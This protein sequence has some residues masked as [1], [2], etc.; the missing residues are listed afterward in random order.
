MRGLIVVG[1]LLLVGCGRA[2]VTEWDTPENWKAAGDSVSSQLWVVRRNGNA[3]RYRILNFQDLPV[4]YI[5]IPLIAEPLPYF[6]DDD[7]ECE[8]IAAHAKST[9]ST[10]RLAIRRRGKDA[11][12][13]LSVESPHPD[14][15]SILVRIN[16]PTAHGWKPVYWVVPVDVG[17]RNPPQ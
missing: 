12:A 11:T 8:V 2:P 7:L 1:L 13:N 14:A 15:K 10:G 5:E 6:G 17:I 16:H 4:E 9:I 3:F